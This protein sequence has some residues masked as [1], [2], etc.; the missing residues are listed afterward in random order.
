M[1]TRMTRFF[2]SPCLVAFSLATLFGCVQHIKMSSSSAPLGAVIEPAKDS[3]QRTHK[4]QLRLPASV[5]IV[6]IVP[7][8]P[9]YV[10]YTT[11]RQA[12]EKLKQQLLTNPKYIS[13]VAVVARDDMQGMISLENIQEIY[14]ADIAIT[15]SYQQDQ[16]S[17]QSGA[18]GLMD[19]AIVGIFFV[20]GVEIKTSSVIDGRV[21]HIPSNSII[22]RASGADERSSHSTTYS[23]NSTAEEESINSIL[24]STTDFGNSLSKVLTKFDNYD[25]SQAVPMA[26]LTAGNSADVAKGK[27]ANDYWRNVDSYKSTGGGAFGII[28]LLISSTLCWAAWCRK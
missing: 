21:I 3:S 20:P 13:S 10:P 8:K 16:R 9:P 7:N 18:A 1:M 5:A 17:S 25:F 14:G 12:A 23:E 22:F 26:V 4:A 19:I 2:I 28:P 11:L 6:T 15:L 27:P 24:A